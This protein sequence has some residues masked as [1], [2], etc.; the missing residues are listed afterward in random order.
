[1]E[2]FTL[3]STIGHRRVCY[4]YKNN[5][6][7][8]YN[9]FSTHIIIIFVVLISNRDTITKETSIFFFTDTILETLYASNK[10]KTPVLPQN[11]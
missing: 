1:M 8:N 7:Y 10:L 2:K 9:L 11:Y 4:C 3:L 5:D 6:I